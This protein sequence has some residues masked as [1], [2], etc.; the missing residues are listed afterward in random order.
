MAKC[1][2]VYVDD[3]K[4]SSV[5]VYLLLLTCCLH[6]PGCIT[7][8]LQPNVAS[9]LSSRG[10]RLR[11]FPMVLR[12]CSLLTSDPSTRVLL[13]RPLSLHHTSYAH[14]LLFSTP[15]NK[16]SVFSWG[17]LGSLKATRPGCSLGLSPLR[18]SSR[19]LHSEW[20]LE[21]LQ[22]DPCCQLSLSKILNCILLLKAEPSVCVS[23]CA[24][25]RAGGT[26]YG[27]CINSSP[28]T[29][30]PERPKLK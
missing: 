18:L 29:I 30:Y 17:S 21:D 13:L 9:S 5:C 19:T 12:S 6:V 23:E 26:L 10:T 22:F 7:L 11:K 28:F 20:K 16:Q 2:T 4:H 27:S 24:S 14:T 25:V 1:S 15:A 3:A 8:K